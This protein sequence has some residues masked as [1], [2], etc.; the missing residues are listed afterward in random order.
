MIF[1]TLTVGAGEVMT[2]LRHVIV[3]YAHGR[4]LFPRCHVTLTDPLTYSTATGNRT[5]TPFPPTP[6]TH[7]ALQFRSVVEEIALADPRGTLCPISFI[8]MQ[9]SAKMLRNNRLVFTGLM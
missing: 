3:A 7:Q 2:R 4:V 6:S 8:F 9:F 5:Q 1:S